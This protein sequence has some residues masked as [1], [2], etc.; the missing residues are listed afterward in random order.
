[1]HLVSIVSKYFSTNPYRHEVLRTTRL[2]YHKENIF[3][4]LAFTREGK[5]EMKER[6]RR[7]V[8]WEALFHS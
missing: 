4:G 3:D 6:L 7:N 2:Q 5:E 1:M 8:G